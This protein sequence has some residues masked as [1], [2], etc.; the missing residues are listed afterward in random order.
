MRALEIVLCVWVAALLVE[1]LARG[2]GRG[3]PVWLGY[4]GGAALVYAQVTAEGYRWQ[5]LPV[6]AVYLGLLLLA[7]TRKGADAPKP[8]WLARVG[9][10]GVGAIALVV[11]V[12]AGLLMP[13]FQVPEPDGP[14]R[15]GTTVFE[16]VDEE[17][18]EP[19]TDDPDDKRRIALQVWYP[20]E[21]RGTS[22]RA[23]WLERPD[24]YAEALS[25]SGPLPAYALSHFN[26]V[27]TNA[28]TDAPIADGAF[29]V[30]VYSHG[31]TAFRAVNTDQVELL[32]SHGYVVISPEH[33]YG[34]MLSVLPSGEAIWNEPNAIPEKE[35][36]GAE[37][38]DEAIQLLVDTYAGDVRFAIDLAE[39]WNAD[40]DS[41]FHE[42]LDLEN[43][44]VFGHSTGAG[45]TVEV[46]AQDER[47]DAGLGMDVW[48][49][50]VTD[51]V[52]AE[53]K[54]TPFMMMDSE[55][56]SGE[57]NTVEQAKL[58]ES[59]EGPAYRLM[60]E[61]TRHNDFTVVT[62]MTPAA[63]YMGLKGPLPGPRVSRIVNDYMLAFFD[64]YLRGEDG[65]ILN[66]SAPYEE[67]EMEVK[68]GDS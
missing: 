37:A 48:A 4:A 29:P 56:W 47:V 26:L 53:P 24:L 50:P 46:V 19:Y 28:W 35:E 22:M 64:E 61:G 21:M 3:A 34:A 25:A 51:S 43:V 9:V 16:Y 15:V 55:V 49:L 68:N 5:M 20:A 57:E 58:W 27:M 10:F 60:I 30:V 17:R 31:W 12:A 62:M 65:D 44:G 1:W 14:Y 42:R 6:Y 11:G 13:V 67:V 36:V 54:D 7:L 52:I 41:I 33:A 45:A 23:P 18:G 2:R 63:P 8:P 40:P 59:L 38:Y 32:A 66:G 39:E